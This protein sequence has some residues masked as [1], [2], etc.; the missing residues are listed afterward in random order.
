MNAVV[1]FVMFTILAVVG[2]PKIIDDQFT[3][4][5][6]TEVLQ[7]VE[8]S[9][10]VLVNSVG[11]NT[12]ADEAG[13][14]ADDRILAIN[15]QQVTGIEEVSQL[16]SENAG[17]TVN[18]LLERNGEQ[19]EVEVTLNEEN[20]GEGYLGIASQSGASGIELR[21][22]TWSAPIVALGLMKQ[23]SQLTFQGLGTA[24]SNLAKASEQVAGPVGIFYILREGA[25]IGLSF[26]L[27][28]IAI[29]SLTLALLNALPI[30]AL[31]G[32][33]LF[34]TLLFAALKKPLSRRMEEAIHGTGFVVLIGLIILITI[35]DVNRF[36]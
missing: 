32:G 20:T 17:D 15:G 8:N 2:M 13:I 23:I 4:A 21:R 35:V 26:I 24:I 18:I 1:A 19:I 3:V 33:R 12:P 34:V 36:F 10:V 28:I 16:T 6:D 30:P 14:E 31:D 5:S 27:F 11:E 29:I 22:S 25:K 9:D 7:E